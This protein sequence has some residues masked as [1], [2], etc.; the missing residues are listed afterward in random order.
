MSLSSGTGRIHGS[1]FSYLPD[2]IYLRKRYEF[3]EDIFVDFSSPGGKPLEDVPI[4]VIANDSWHLEIVEETSPGI[5]GV[6]WAPMR[7]ELQDEAGVVVNY[8]EDFDKP[9]SEGDRALEVCVKLVALSGPAPDGTLVQCSTDGIY[10]FIDLVST[11]A[12]AVSY[13]IVPWSMEFDLPTDIAVPAGG[14]TSQREPQRQ[15]ALVMP[16]PDRAVIGETW[17]SVAVSASYE[18]GGLVEDEEICVAVEVVGGSATLDG[19]SA[20]CSDTGVLVFN[21]LSYPGGEEIELR[22]TQVEPDLVTL[23]DESVYPPLTGE[24]VEVIRP[25]FRF[26]AT[27]PPL[28][29]IGALQPFGF[30]VELTDPEGQ[31]LTDLEA[32]I[33][34]QTSGLALAP[35]ES[36]FACTAGGYATFSDLHF[37]SYGADA[38]EL[39]HVGPG[40]EPDGRFLAPD[41]HAVEVFRPVLVYRTGEELPSILEPAEEFGAVVDVIDPLGPRIT[42]INYCLTMSSEAAQPALTV[43][44][45]VCSSSGSVTFSGASF[46]NAGEAT[47]NLTHVAPD[48]AVLEVLEPPLPHSVIILSAA[49]ERLEFSVAPPASAN[50]GEIWQ[51]FAVSALDSQGRLAG[52]QPLPVSIEATG[53]TGEISG[54]LNVSTQDGVAPFVGVSYLTDAATSQSVSVR[55]TAPGLI[56]TDWVEVEVVPQWVEILDFAA[57]EFFGTPGESLELS[58][59]TTGAVSCEITPGVGSVLPPS[60]SV[61]YSLPESFSGGTFELDCTGLNGP[62]S[63]ETGWVK[64]YQ[65]VPEDTIAFGGWDECGDIASLGM[66]ASSDLLV[67]GISDYLCNGFEAI[68]DAMIH[69]RP[70]APYGHALGLLARRLTN[71]RGSSLVANIRVSADEH[72][73]AYTSAQ[74][75]DPNYPD[76]PAPLAEAAVFVAE[77]DPDTRDISSESLV[78]L[79]P[80][81][82][83][84]PVVGDSAISYDGRFVAFVRKKS[85]GVNTA[86]QWIYVRDRSTGTT[87]LAVTTEDPPFDSMLGPLAI[88]ADGQY[89]TFRG[90]LSNQPSYLQPYVVNVA[91]GA[92]EALGVG[93]NPSSPSNINLY[94]VSVDLSATGR[95]AVFSTTSDGLVEEDQNGL[96]DIYVRDRLLGNTTR[97]SVSRFGNELDGG[98]WS[99]SLSK[100]LDPQRDGRFV[101]FVS[102]ARNLLHPDELT[103]DYPQIYVYDRDPDGDGFDNG[104][105]SI[106]RVSTRVDPVTGD[107]VANSTARIREPQIS[108]DGRVVSYVGASHIL[109]DT[110]NYYSDRIFVSPHPPKRARPQ[111]HRFR[112]NT[113]H[114]VRTD[115]VTLEWSVSKAAECVI[116]PDVGVVDPLGSVDVYPLDGV[117]IE[118]PQNVTYTLTCNREE[119]GEGSL[120]LD[121]Q[122]DPLRPFVRTARFQCL[123]EGVAGLDLDG[124]YFVGPNLELLYSFDGGADQSI[125]LDN[126]ESMTA[127]ST[128]NPD[129]IIIPVWSEYSGDRMTVSIRRN[130]NPVFE[131]YE[132]TIGVIDPAQ[133]CTGPVPS[134]SRELTFRS[135]LPETVTAGEVWPRIE[136]DVRDSLFGAVIPGHDGTVLE[137][138][139][140]F[141]TAPLFG[142]LTSTITDGVAAFDNV[143]MTEAQNARF[144]V[145]AIG[146]PP[147]EPTIRGNLG[148]FVVEPATPDHL[149]FSL[150]PGL[151]QVVSVPW[152]TFAV[153]LRDE[154]ENVVTQDA[155]Q[156]C[157]DIAVTQGI[158]S[159]S[160]TTSCTSDGVA[161]FDSVVHE[162][163]EEVVY[164]VRAA[165][166]PPITGLDMEILPPAIVIESVE[167]PCMYPGAAALDIRGYHMDVP[168]PQLLVSVDG[169]E[170][171]TPIALLDDPYSTVEYGRILQLEP[172]PEGEFL[173]VRLRDGEDDSTSFQ[174]TAPLPGADGAAVCDNAEPLRLEITQLGAGPYTAGVAWPPFEVELRTPL[175]D[176]V[177]PRSSVGVVLQAVSGNEPLLGSVMSSLS[178]G[179][180]EYDDISYQTAGSLEIRAVLSDGPDEFPAVLPSNE[181]SVDIAANIPTQLA[182]DLPPRNFEIVGD[183]WREFVV[184]VQDEYGNRVPDASHC[185]DIQAYGV[186]E[187]LQGTLGGT[188]TECAAGGLISFD[189][190][191]YD[192]QQLIEIDVA[193][194]ELT[195]I[196]GYQVG[197]GL[198]A[199]VEFEADPAAQVVAGETW[200]PVEVRLVD[201]NGDLQ[202]EATDCLE[203]VAGSATSALLG[204]TTR[205]AAGGRAI[206]DDLQYLKAETITIR[207]GSGL[208][209]PTPVAAIEVLPATPERVRTVSDPI[210]LPIIAGIGWPTIE[211]EIVDRYG[212]RTPSNALVSVVPTEGAGEFSGNLVTRH[213]WQGAVS[214]TRLAYN[215]AESVVFK[216]VSPGIGASDEQVAQVIPNVPSELRFNPG[217]LRTQTSG[218]EWPSFTVRLVDR[219]GNTAVNSFDTPL[220][221]TANS[222]SGREGTLSAGGSAWVETTAQAG[223]AAFSGVSYSG[224][225]NIQIQVDALAGYSVQST[226]P[227]LVSVTAAP[228]TVLASGDIDAAAGGTISIPDTDPS[229]FAGVTLTIPPGALPADTEVQLMASIDEIEAAH[230]GSY[231]LSPTLEILPSPLYFNEPVELQM[232]VD[233]SSLDAALPLL[234][235]GVVR[236]DGAGGEVETIPL[237][238]ADF[239]DNLVSFQIEHLSSFTVAATPVDPAAS[240]ISI[241]SPVSNGSTHVVQ[242]GSSDAIAFELNLVGQGGIDLDCAIAANPWDAYGLALRAANLGDP[243]AEAISSSLSAAADW[244]TLV[245]DGP[246]DCTTATGSFTLTT[247]AAEYPPTVFVEG[248]V[249]LTPEL[250]LPTAHLP[251]VDPC[252]GARG[253]CV[254]PFVSPA[255]PLYADNPANDA[256]PNLS[257]AQFVCGLPG[258][259]ALELVGENFFGPGLEIAFNANGN[260]W[261]TWRSLLPATSEAAAVIES[262]RI[263]YF[264]FAGG[265]DSGDL[266]DIRLRRRSD[267]GY[268]SNVVS[269]TM[270]DFQTAC[271]LAPRAEVRATAALPAQVAAGKPWPE[272]T[273]VIWSQSLDI[274]IPLS[275]VQ[276]LLSLESGAAVLKGPNAEPSGIPILVTNGTASVRGVSYPLAETIELSLG[277]PSPQASQL[278]EPLIFDVDV[279]GGNSVQFA[280]DQHPPEKVVVGRTWPTFSVT[281]ADALGN[282]ASSGNHCIALRQETGIGSISGTLEK[283]FENGAVELD[284][285]TYDQL[286]SFSFTVLVD[287]SPL[288]DPIEV[289]STEPFPVLEAVSFPCA[290]PQFAVTELLGS[291]FR[292]N[293]MELVIQDPLGNE[294]AATPLVDGQGISI[295]GDRALLYQSAPEDNADFHYGIRVDGILVASDLI[296]AH[297]PD[298]VAAC[299]GTPAARLRFGVPPSSKAVATEFWRPFSV[300]LYSAVAGLDG[301]ALQVPAPFELAISSGTGDFVLGSQA[302]GSDSGTA[303][304]DGVQYPVAESVQFDVVPVGVPEDAVEAIRN[305][306][307]LVEAG[308]AVQVVWETQPP[309]DVEVS[310]T[311]SEFSVLVQDELGNVLTGSDICISLNPADGNIGTFFGNLSRCVETGRAVFSD[312]TYDKEEIAAFT[313][314]SPAVDSALVFSTS[315]YDPA[316]SIDSAIYS[317]YAP[318]NLGLAVTGTDFDGSSLELV[319]VR[320]GGLEETVA[321][322]S[323]ITPTSAYL[324]TIPAEVGDL[325]EVRVRRENDDARSSSLIPLGQP[326]PDEDIECVTGPAPSLSL[327]SD[328]MMQEYVGYRW[329]PIVVEV[330]SEVSKTRVNTLDGQV[331]S[332]SLVSGT[333]EL[334]G[335]LE[336]TIVDGLVAFSELNY[337]MV[338]SVELAIAVPSAPAVGGIVRNV[339]E[340]PP[341]LKIESIE[342]ECDGPDLWLNV[343]GEGFAG[344]MDDYNVDVS[345]EHIRPDL[346]PEL[347]TF[348]LNLS[349]VVESS[350]WQVSDEG[351]VFA[352]WGGSDKVLEVVLQVSDPISGAEDQI[353]FIQPLPNELCSPFD[354]SRGRFASFDNDVSLVGHFVD[355]GVPDLLRIENGFLHFYENTGLGQ[356]EPPTFVIGDVPESQFKVFGRVA[357]IDEDSR[358]EA[359]VGS[360]EGLIIVSFFDNMAGVDVDRIPPPSIQIWNLVDLLVADITGDSCPELVTDWSGPHSGTSGRY[361]AVNQCDGTFSD[362]ERTELPL[363]SGAVIE[364]IDG[365][366]KKDLVLSG[367]IRYDDGSLTFSSELYNLTDSAGSSGYFSGGH[368][369][370]SD[371]TNNGL[372]DIGVFGS[373]VTG[374][375]VFDQMRLYEQ[376]EPRSFTEIQRVRAGY[377][378]PTQITR[379]VDLDGDGLLDVVGT[380]GL[381][382]GNSDIF[383]SMYNIDGEELRGGASFQY[384]EFGAEV[385]GPRANDVQVTDL[386][387]DGYPDYVVTFNDIV[388]ERRAPPLFIFGK[389]RGEMPMY[390]DLDDGVEFVEFPA[391]LVE[392]GSGWPAFTVQI[393]DFSG[394]PIDHDERCAFISVISDNEAKISGTKRHCTSSGVVVFDD[395]SY[396][397]A[398]TISFKVVSDGGASTNVSSV[399]VVE[400]D[401]L[402]NPP[403]IEGTPSNAV[404]AGDAYYFQPLAD[405][406]DLLSGSEVL[407]FGIANQPFWSSFDPLTGTLSGTP[408]GTDVGIYRG[409]TIS[410]EDLAG[411]VATLEPFA[412]TVVDFNA[413]PTISGSPGTVID[414]G[415]VYEFTP[416]AS[417]PD[418]TELSFSVTNLPDWLGIDEETGTLAGIPGNGDVGWHEAIN[419]SVSDGVN[420]PVWLGEFSIEVINVNDPPTIVGNPTQ[421]L[422]VGDTYE[423]LP[424]LDDPDFIFGD[425]IEISLSGTLPT[426]ASF[427]S[428]TGRISGVPQPGDEGTETHGISVLVTDLSGAMDAVGP[429]SIIVQG[430]VTVPPN[431]EDVVPLSAMQVTRNLLKDWEFLY[432]NSGPG[433]IQFEVELDSMTS[434]QA[435][436]LVGVVRSTDGEMLPGVKVSLK[437][438]PEF[439]YTYTRKDGEYTL[440]VRGGPNRILEF[441][442]DGFVKMQRVIDSQWSETVGVPPVLMTPVTMPETLVS[443]PVSSVQVARAPAPMSEDSYEQRRPTFLFLPGTTAE[444]VMPDGSAVPLSELHL[445]FSELVTSPEQWAK[446]PGE[447]PEG[448]DAYYI[449]AIESREVRELGASHVQFSRPV[450]QLVEN[451][452]GFAIGLDFGHAI[453]DKQKAAWIPKNDSHVMEVLGADLSGDAQL[454]V[455]GHGE[456]ADA[457]LLE[458]FGVDDEEL[459]TI[460]SLYPGG[461]QLVRATTDRFSINCWSCVPNKL[462]QS[463][464][465]PGLLDLSPQDENSCKIPNSSS[466][467]VQNGVLEESIPVSGTPYNLSYTS[468]R[469]EGYRDDWRVDI[470]IQLPGAPTEDF[471][472]AFVTVT[473]GSGQTESR[474]FSRNAHADPCQG[475]E[476]YWTRINGRWNKESKVVRLDESL[477]FCVYRLPANRI[478]SWEWNGQDG[479]GRPYKYATNVTINTL[480]E[481]EVDSWRQTVLQESQIDDYTLA[482][483]APPTTFGNAPRLRSIGLQEAAC[484][485]LPLL[486]KI[487]Y[488][489]C[490]AVAR[491]YSRLSGWINLNHGQ[492]TQQMGNW[493]IDVLHAY[494]ADNAVLR[495]G[496][497]NVEARPRLHRGDQRYFSAFGGDYFSSFLQDGIPVSRARIQ[498]PGKL[499]VDDLGRTYFVEPAANRVRRIELDGTVT[500]VAGSAFGSAC[501][502][503]TAPC[504][505]GGPAN[506]ALLHGPRGIA[507]GQD[508]SL[509]I[510]DTL[511]HRIRRVSPDGTIET[512]AGTGEQGF[513]GDDVIAAGTRLNLPR[514]VEFDGNDSTYF[515]ADAGNN[516]VRKVLPDG[517][518]VTIAGDRGEPAPDTELVYSHFTPFYYPASL[519]RLDDGSLVVAELEAQRVRMITP[520]YQV[521]EIV[522]LGDVTTE[523]SVGLAQDARGYL[524]V[525]DHLGE[526]NGN[527]GDA[528]WQ[529]W[530]YDPQGARTL[531]VGCRNSCTTSSRAGHRIRLERPGGLAV[532]PDDRLYVSNTLEDRILVE[533]TVPSGDIGNVEIFSQDGSEVYRF[534]GGYGDIRHE[535]TLDA[536][537][538]HLKWQFGY[539]RE[540]R[541]QRIIDRNGLVT[542]IDRDASGD[543]TAIIAPSGRRTEL[544]TDNNGNLTAIVNPAGERWEFDYHFG[545]MLKATRDPRAT[546]WN[547]DNPGSEYNTSEY[548]YYDLGRFWYALDAEGGAKTLSGNFSYLGRRWYLNTQDAARKTYITELS[549]APNNRDT[550]LIERRKTYL[551]DRYRAITETRIPY[552]ADQKDFDRLTLVT[553]PDYSMT[554]LSTQSPYPGMQTSSYTEGW[555]YSTLGAME[556]SSVSWRSGGTGVESWGA[557]EFERPTYLG[558]RVVLGDR[559]FETRMA[560]ERGNPSVLTDD[561]HVITQTSPEGREVTG[562]LDHRGRV[563]EVSVPGLASV[564]VEYDS[565]GRP[566]RLVQRVCDAPLE[567]PCSDDRELSFGYE[568]GA[569]GAFDPAGRLENILDPLGRSVSFAYDAADRVRFQTLPDGRDM[570]FRYDAGGDLAA[571]LPPSDAPA[572][573]RPVHE[574]SYNR[575]GRPDSYAPPQPDP[576]DPLPET[577]TVYR[578]D[579]AR[580]PTRIIR[581]DGQ[582]V[583][584]FYEPDEDLVER[585]TQNS[586]EGYVQRFVSIGYVQGGDGLN[587]PEWLE[588][589]DGERLD[590]EYL[591][592]IPWRTTWSGTVEG[593]VRRSYDKFGMP[594]S[595]TVEAGG[596]SVGIGIDIDDDGLFLGTYDPD[597][598]EPLLTV[599][600]EPETG[601]ED[602]TAQGLVTTD[603][604][605]N[606]FAETEHYEAFA[607]TDLVYQVD[608]IRDQVGR[609][610]IKTERIA[611]PGTGVLGDPV[612]TEY[613]YEDSLYGDMGRLER[614]LVD[615]VPTESYDYDANGNRVGVDRGA[616]PGDV[617]MYDDQ[618]RLNTYDREGNAESYEY[619]ANG[620]LLSKTAAGGVT[621]YQYDLLGALR[622]VTLPDG[623]QIDYVIDGAGRRIGKK[624]NGVLDYGLLY[625]DD[626]N[627]VAQL[628]GSGNLVSTFAYG[629]RPNVPDSMVQNGR[630]YRIVSDHLGS[631]RLVI[632]VAGGTIAERIDYGPWGRVTRHDITGP[633]GYVPIPF[634][635]AGGLYDPDTG[636]VRFGARDYDPALGRWTAKDPILFGGGDPNLYGYVVGDPVN[637][638]DLN[639]LDRLHFDGQYLTWLDDN[640]FLVDIWDGVS[641]P[642]GRGRLPEGI[643]NV[644]DIVALPNVPANNAYCDATGSCWWAPLQPRFQTNRTSLGIH[645]DGNLPGT[646]GCVGV[647]NSNTS[648][649]LRRLRDYG[650]SP[651][652]PLELEVE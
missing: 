242:S 547:L 338:E 270:P 166:L 646:E 56:P 468:S 258:N 33:A 169:G 597:T 558:D 474:A 478:W 542:M 292:R 441:E 218:D 509:L 290:A 14:A 499:I 377:S 596:E 317:C 127:G 402:N 563:E 447:L 448:T 80:D 206:F 652:N 502:T 173:T 594:L 587:Q 175:E 264:D 523:S 85:T 48:G 96:A 17:D 593:I 226:E 314:N 397:I 548:E 123:V 300:E 298:V 486:P 625:Q 32:C 240:S 87:E 43:N 332:I 102:E 150:Q 381:G 356:F 160:G 403:T 183:P 91:T 628:D 630:S 181:V 187:A 426:W 539:D 6:T 229:P 619:S 7:V 567:L 484:S 156:R 303:W 253:E 126:L 19:T 95:H 483:A 164:D 472:A 154:F 469:Q 428:A 454:D 589:G 294:V 112:S 331:A 289:I 248:E 383:T 438:A 335:M 440:L 517:R 297:S 491:L 422:S 22:F 28:G 579:K 419:I 29:R 649:F 595:Q 410:V 284:D 227:L 575:V 354:R 627:P 443:F 291:D 570:E 66:S 239:S 396:P 208:S 636:L 88:S 81:G 21:D 336:R 615:G 599:V 305:V 423:Y 279:Q 64:L 70:Q 495:R 359:I 395:L 267:D 287:G 404:V 73:V 564:L 385:P 121:I 470:P 614:V 439:G 318:G 618:D 201:A 39:V 25:E 167:F 282:P 50:A 611:D 601:I 528:V 543:A 254:E 449:V 466:I 312:I 131:S 115:P 130:D 238:D 309:A 534:S 464:R 632:D 113:D 513:D 153:D 296:P 55:A 78:S 209:A 79:L 205:C 364:D 379:V 592:S 524:Y 526:G 86:E 5:V 465:R 30:A 458:R 582:F 457:A 295:D 365:D 193:S 272:F 51:T 116:E 306:E 342:I 613:I 207:I 210:L 358:D 577:G 171:S 344:V 568:T 174:L 189:D 388:P 172:V 333:G 103:R 214:F 159:T 152:P 471:L 406:P 525:T 363:P 522:N 10:E 44:P 260:G 580:R 223:L 368:A 194:T 529:V 631:P 391:A 65:R 42:D 500:T 27:D 498:Q 485:S 337:D 348:E 195:N 76:T 20:R 642:W 401:D 311:W 430:P 519:L 322:P 505:D 424:Q 235:F 429:F 633:A 487:G 118:S 241:L 249:T 608:Y 165:G 607:G 553:R 105:F 263:V 134:G 69:H 26:L 362:W 221:L 583:R 493:E 122:V 346:P 89:V 11:S 585:I 75:R 394:E 588:T 132:R 557:I 162:T 93:A 420:E 97:I 188:L 104:D 473:T 392:A 237:L 108:A 262:E 643:Y 390:T 82:S 415:Q 100:S 307:V 432:T 63:A 277:I 54:V 301:Q 537:T 236:S 3:A 637:G 352:P 268:L 8:V 176:R 139:P 508:G 83:S 490:V 180:S 609:I 179:I 147:G 644:T 407:T 571:L 246:A 366:Q 634:G 647:S 57:G 273:A 114:V 544:E 125:P 141:G 47:I 349:G 604:D 98:S 462:S 624:I 398:E 94:G 386:D 510:A 49:P 481:F 243:R 375:I 106:E 327:I 196:E 355:D 286:G 476:V 367:L 74:T 222:L 433:Q 212:N 561:Y 325:L 566:T 617:A 361:M 378:V 271:A 215:V 67:W 61:E 620:E 320:N 315:V 461:Q 489:G 431:P 477:G 621:S 538:G 640:G 62:V 117:E 641:G 233:A 143:W 622:A 251:F 124:A 540:D 52:T 482:V 512:I 324:H 405:D 357:N 334:S 265:F 185:V 393:V 161:L 635:F 639:G 71:S 600:R 435:S 146:I 231:V 202:E 412:I 18:T 578:Y 110:P 573:E 616:A 345:I 511:N 414:Q 72:V 133:T 554:L 463:L 219:F 186:S 467:D 629:T 2:T 151:T 373:L 455:I 140:A 353:R 610:S 576:A 612:E 574:F 411:E 591:S 626:L 459:A 374:D 274:P 111:F 288:G 479:A 562:I 155:E 285:L 46:D 316:P 53:G 197:V 145:R 90:Q 565:A 387:L 550:S 488:V 409:I 38:I 23:R 408:T 299:V 192:A 252:N 35:V 340:D 129:R 456:V 266:L 178:E 92:T 225:G 532:G 436:L 559:I 170:E 177:I 217:P 168:D 232:P 41:S 427:D 606:A 453:Y 480:S 380:K 339:I 370:V 330:Q 515:V 107:L 416:V 244:S 341:P 442:R 31:V 413:D 228:G 329:S 350:E 527:R 572:G 556:M 84:A 278:L 623:T 418:D 211:A 149:A 276:L 281:G 190:V 261:E 34:L 531:I 230:D 389:R 507:L 518:M 638:I 545:S 37:E 535:A 425:S 497:G 319:I 119:G 191:Y 109:A 280:F 1:S 496:D 144:Y 9:L 371:F 293:G 136:V 256:L 245:Y 521:Q 68:P 421:I 204:T 555:Y 138:L 598:E 650:P 533:L 259:G 58:W 501:P 36:T 135:P 304:F 16:L 275:G 494:D 77:L 360:E 452:K 460:A 203:V 586:A 99:P 213:A 551:G 40:G 12:A 184:T 581:P 514:D 536:Y 60:G 603:I 250:Y 199:A 234:A 450:V 163:V 255:E 546:A 302:V 308:T 310:E 549:N 351:F 216:L 492:S 504:G 13:E 347:A 326:L 605:V 323:T 434:K 101:T 200:P 137:L 503:P 369:V 446:V 247:T 343:V 552:P 182:F 399:V 541:V 602:V 648:D 417:D 506:Q 313:L 328:R 128:V 651:E 269:A 384:S 451:F 45:V 224:F 475:T 444:A 445:Q 382:Q 220:R 157:I 376:T 24:V 321:D 4:Q 198:P 15:L 590:Y 584:L 645:P 372:L 283:C 59:D 257:S 400:S 437:G 560:L 516:R 530:P 569:G 148:E 120:S 158:G 142:T 520:E